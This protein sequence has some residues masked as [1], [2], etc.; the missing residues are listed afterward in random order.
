MK[1]ALVTGIT[2]QD[3][4]Y[5]SELLLTRGY[6]V[7]GLARNSAATSRAAL[8][9][10]GITDH[11][12]LAEGDLTDA[13]G[14]RRIVSQIRPHEVYNLAAQSRVRTSW[15]QPLLTGA[16]T[17]LGTAN[18]LEAVRVE[19]PE[20]RFFQASSAE[21]FGHADEPLQTEK[22]P[23]RPRSPYATAKLYAH[24]MTANYRESFGLFAASGIMFT[25][26]SPIRPV[27]FVSRKVTDGVA[28]IKLG[29]QD[30]LTLGNVDV[31]RDW[32]HARDYVRAMWLMLQRAEPDDFV[33][34]T[35]RRVSILDFCRIAFAHVGLDAETHLVSDTHLLRPAEIQCLCG[36]ASKARQ[37][38]G[39]MPEIELEA[40]I[41]EMVD[42][43]LAR[44][45]DEIKS[46]VRSDSEA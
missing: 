9:W 4:A 21:M 7:Y 27:D 38:L 41:R 32:G 29:L 31:Q 12:R 13:S 20:A 25:H 34:A 11:I 8:E 42:A 28:R 39:W 43:D 1:R 22:T 10:L 46:G 40:M 16:V 24:W 37:K 35:G 26:D 18:L 44:V 45:R 14:L 2:G 6:E 3:G 19:Y 17:A 30:V 36:D 33:I 5:L 15:D 23:F